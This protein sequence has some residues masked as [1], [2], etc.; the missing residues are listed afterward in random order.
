[1]LYNRWW[2]AAVAGANLAGAVWGFAWYADQLAATPWLWW[3]LIPDSPL[4]A[5]LF[6]LFAW[7]LATGRTVAGWSWSLAAWLAVLGVLKY[8][9]WTTLGF[10]YY[11]A[12]GNFTPSLT[13]WFL[14]VSH[15][16]MALEGLLYL[17][18]LPERPGA[19]AA[20]LAWLGLNDLADYAWGTHPTLPRPQ[21]VALACRAA[22]VLTALNGVMTVY[23]FYRR[24]H[25]FAKKILH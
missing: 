1:M 19:A 12:Q 16:G 21:D 13:E 22:V 10:T 6:G 17:P 2:L 11:L 8:G 9:L 24:P 5:M 4:T 7:R 18:A 23:F 15:I 20:V 3:P 25:F 14:Y